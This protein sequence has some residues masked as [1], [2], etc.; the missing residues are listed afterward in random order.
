M[1]TYQRA[2]QQPRAGDAGLGL[3]GECAEYRFCVA[4]QLPAGH[5]HQDGFLVREVAVQRADTDSGPR[6]YGIGTQSERALLFDN[7]SGGLENEI[8]CVQGTRLPGLGPLKN[9]DLMLF[10]GHGVRPLKSEYATGTITRISLRCLPA[11]CK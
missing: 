2:Y 11:G 1:Q 8:A 4:L 6:C 5:R 10:P 7:P 3:A 9:N